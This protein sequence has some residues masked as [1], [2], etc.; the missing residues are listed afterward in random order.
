MHKLRVKKKG[1]KKIY[2]IENILK[3]VIWRDQ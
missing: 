3:L 2:N 1:N